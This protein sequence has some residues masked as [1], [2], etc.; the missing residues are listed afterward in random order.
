M[1]NDA[2]SAALETADPPTI[3]YTRFLIATLELCVL[4]REEQKAAAEACL[5][6][7]QEHGLAVWLL[8]AAVVHSWSIAAL[9]RTQSVW[10]ELRR[11]LSACRA[12]GQRAVASW[13]Y[14]T[15]AYGEAEV[16]DFDAGSEIYRD[17]YNRA[18]RAAFLGL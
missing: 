2:I 13:V 12:Q 3:A 15:L 14:S 9:N 5:A 7:A 6:L 11:K 8:I 4:T 10:D 18:R 16:G 17:G 1:I